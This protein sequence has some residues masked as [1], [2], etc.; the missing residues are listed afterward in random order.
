MDKTGFVYEKASEASTTL[1]TSYVFAGALAA[2]TGSSATIGST[3]APG[4]LD[5]LLALLQ[6][7]SADG[8]TPQGA[9]VADD[10]DFA[11]PLANSFYLKASFGENAEDLAKN[12]QLVLSS[13]QISG[14][15]DQLEY[16]DLRF[17]DRVYYKFKG[18]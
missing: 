11:V 18:S 2:A 16:V 15:E 12:L 3:F 7:L 1:A 10:E 13:D 5:G 4:H 9:N 8:F 17:G 14:K 6:F